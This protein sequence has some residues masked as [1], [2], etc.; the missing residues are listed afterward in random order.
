MSGM[1]HGSESSRRDFL[2][3]SVTTASG[4]LVSSLGLAA[5]VH[6]RGKERFNIALIGTGNR[7]TGAAA[8]C[9]N[10]AKHLRLAAAQK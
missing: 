3:G 6:A 5:S 10:V 2:K 9:L 8:D 7:G 1:E 4:A